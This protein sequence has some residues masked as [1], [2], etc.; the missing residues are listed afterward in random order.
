[1]ATAAKYSCRCHSDVKMEL[2]KMI[3][4]KTNKFTG[5]LFSVYVIFMCLIGYYFLNLS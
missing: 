1:M 3:Q 2:Q 5:D 4:I